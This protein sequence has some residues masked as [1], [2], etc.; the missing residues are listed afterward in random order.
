MKSTVLAGSAEWGQGASKQ[1]GQTVRSHEIATFKRTGSNENLF[2]NDGHVNASDRQDL[3]AAQMDYLRQKGTKKSTIRACV[4]HTL[5]NNPDLKAIIQSYQA[6]EGV[7]R[8]YA[9]ELTNVLTKVVR[10]FSHRD[11]F[12]A[13]LLNPV[14]LEKKQIIEIKKK[15]SRPEVFYESEGKWQ[16]ANWADGRFYPRPKREKVNLT[17]DG[18]TMEDA[19][20]DFMEGLQMDAYEQTAWKTD[21]KFYDLLTSKDALSRSFSPDT[22]AEIQGNQMANFPVSTLLCS[23]AVMPELVNTNNGWH[24]YYSEHYKHELLVQGKLGHVMGVDIMTEIYWDNHLKILE[25]GDF[26]FLAEPTILGDFYYDPDF[27][28]QPLDLSLVQ[29]DGAGFF[30]IYRE[31][32]LIYR[33]KAFI[34][35]KKS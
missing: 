1:I 11:G 35:C 4:M 22:L 30:G 20:E 10:E 5:N 13:K 32:L 14:P 2:N 3:Q 16:A 12:T 23:T 21:K 33:M 28:L 34:R 27:E 15:P 8:I 31:M 9:A 7:N 24:Y 17:V 19:A 6:S 18:D 29:R 25:A 26:F